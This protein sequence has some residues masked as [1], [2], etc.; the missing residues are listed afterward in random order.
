MRQ[1]MRLDRLFQAREAYHRLGAD[2]GA[3]PWF[4]TQYTRVAEDLASGAL[5]FL[6]YRGGHRHSFATASAAADAV[7]ALVASDWGPEAAGG[8][9]A[10]LD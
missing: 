2:A 7:R 4:M 8:A 3:P 1:V 6:L 9:W 10:R 5:T